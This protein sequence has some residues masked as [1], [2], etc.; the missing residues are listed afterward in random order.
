MYFLALSHAPPEFDMKIAIITPVTIDPPRSPPS[1]WAPSP[2]PT[3]YRSKHCHEAGEDNI[4]RSAAAVEMS[5]QRSYSGRPVPSMMPGISLNCL[6]TS[7]IIFSA[8]LLTAWMEKALKRNGKKASYE[9]SDHYLWG[10]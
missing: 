4:S 2:N 9:E 10:P 5:T 7:S 6:R 1:A 3:D 8:A